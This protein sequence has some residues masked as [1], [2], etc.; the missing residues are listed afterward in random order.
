L[1]ALSERFREVTIT[2]ETPSPLP[3]NL[4]ASWL[5]PEVADCVI[6]FVHRSYEEQ[7]T[8][9]ELAGLFPSARNFS[10]EPMPLRSIFLAMAKSGR[11]HSPSVAEAAKRVEA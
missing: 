6:H 1:P 7:T 8:E 2:L 3:E 4:P 9:R 10:F 11:N 5:Q